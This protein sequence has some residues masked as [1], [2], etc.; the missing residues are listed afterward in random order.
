MVQNAI[1]GKNFDKAVFGND[2]AKLKQET[3][4]VRNR[5]LSKEEIDFYLLMALVFHDLP[6]KKSDQLS[7][8][9]GAVVKRC[10]DLTFHDTFQVK[11][12]HTESHDTRIKCIRGV[13]LI[14]NTLPIPK[15][16]SYN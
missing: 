11:K 12:M 15:F 7:S 9:L 14:M 8:L 3:R 13:N 1:L 10:I 6:R 16:I 5:M 4:T 2:S